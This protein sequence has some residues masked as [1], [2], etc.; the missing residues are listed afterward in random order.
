MTVDNGDGWFGDCF[1][2]FSRKI[3]IS[4]REKI[5]NLWIFKLEKFNIFVKEFS[6]Q[7]STSVW[8]YI[9]NIF[10]AAILECWISKMI[11]IKRI[12]VNFKLF[13]WHL[14][15]EW[16]FFFGKYPT[17]DTQ[18]PYF[19]AGFFLSNPS[20][21][22]VALKNFHKILLKTFEIIEIWTLVNIPWQISSIEA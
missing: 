14:R 16:D 15:F 22:C 18:K 7:Q 21:Y 6:A 5:L 11:D 19:D 12:K 4:S 17:F 1:D 20:F 2:D 10:K 13:D 3:Q 9:F 8:Y